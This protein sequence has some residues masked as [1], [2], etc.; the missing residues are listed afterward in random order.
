M[1]EQEQKIRDEI[2][3]AISSLELEELDE[4]QAWLD[5]KREAERQAL[6]N[7]INCLISDMT[8]EELE[9][10]EGYIAKG[11]IEGMA[12]LGSRIRRLELQ[13]KAHDARF[14]M[15]SEDEGHFIVTGDKLRD[16]EMTLEQLQEFEHSL[17]DDDIL[18]IITRCKDETD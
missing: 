14:Y 6:F 16:V 9:Q 1:T 7:S 4:L 12:T 2:A 15:A 18:F 5:E 10:V 13:A 3:R 11:E 8:V 17:N